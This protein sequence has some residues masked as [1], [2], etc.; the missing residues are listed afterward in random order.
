MFRFVIPQCPKAHEAVE[1]PCKFPALLI[2]TSSF[3][4]IAVPG[5]EI[6]AGSLRT[7]ECDTAAVIHVM[8]GSLF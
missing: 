7:D 2:L 1:E 3:I 4:C 8:R 6:G 5:E